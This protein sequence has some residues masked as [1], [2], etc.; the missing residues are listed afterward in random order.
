MLLKQ[1]TKS[2]ENGVNHKNSPCILFCRSFHVS[3]QNTNFKAVLALFYPSLSSHQ[4]ISV[5]LTTGHSISIIAQST[6]PLCHPLMCFHQERIGGMLSGFLFIISSFVPLL[7][8]LLPE[9]LISLL[10]T[11]LTNEEA[12]QHEANINPAA[13]LPF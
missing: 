10:F 12:S 4:S 11:I 9:N 3:P 1:S 6:P 2:K 13:T 5:L 8:F 7:I